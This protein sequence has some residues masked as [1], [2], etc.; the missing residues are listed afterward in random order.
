[1]VSLA[2]ALIRLLNFTLPGHAVPPQEPPEVSRQPET[3][4]LPGGWSD[5]GE[6][7]WIWAVGTQVWPDAQDI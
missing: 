3:F 5:A 6:A 2:P 7:V 1:M 4:Q